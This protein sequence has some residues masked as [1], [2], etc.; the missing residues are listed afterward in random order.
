V[1]RPEILIWFSAS[2][3][4]FVVGVAGYPGREG[5]ITVAIKA[6]SKFDVAQWWKVLHLISL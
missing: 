3:D 5:G 1:A 6:A 4:R 2:A